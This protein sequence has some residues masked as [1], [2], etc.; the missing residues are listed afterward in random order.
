MYVCM[1]ICSFEELEGK[2]FSQHEIVLHENVPRKYVMVQ[3]AKVSKIKPY[4]VVMHFE[5]HYS[6]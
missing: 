4:L 5:T 6:G 1:Y 2:G 3:Q